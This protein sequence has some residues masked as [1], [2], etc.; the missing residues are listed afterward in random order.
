MLVVVIMPISPCIERIGLIYSKYLSADYIGL[1]WGKERQMC[2]IMED[3]KYSDA[4]KHMDNGSNQ[5]E[6]VVNEDNCQDFI[7]NWGAKRNNS[8]LVVSLAIGLHVFFYLGHLLGLLLHLSDILFIL[9]LQQWHHINIT[10]IH[11]RK[12]K[13]KIYIILK[14]NNN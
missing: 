6:I 11:T 1:H 3:D 5:C 7:C 2:H 10:V 9:N 12:I 14:T 8:L 13:R 4:V